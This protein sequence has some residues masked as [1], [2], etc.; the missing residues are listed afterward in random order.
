V[1]EEDDV[2]DH[3]RRAALVGSY[4]VAADVVAGVQ[5]EQLGGPT[6]CGEYD[7]AAVVDHLVGAGWRAVALGRGES[8]PGDGFPHVELAEAPDQLRQAG[9]EAQAAWSDDASLARTMTMPWGETY[10]GATLVNMYLSELAAHTWDVAVATGQADRLD[11]PLAKS[12]LEGARAM[13][14]PEYRDAMG[15]GNPFG[16]EVEPPADATEWERFVAFTGRPPRDWTSPT[17]T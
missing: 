11:P 17:R 2:T 16:A 12:A 1:P 5:P 6:P 10:T 3:D 14:R 4:A 8:P 15:R 13:L 9:R 7:V